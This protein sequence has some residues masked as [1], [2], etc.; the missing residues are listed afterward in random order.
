MNLQSIL[1]AGMTDHEAAAIEIM[2]GMTWRDHRCVALK[3]EL[4][5]GVPAQSALARACQSCVVDLF[6]LGMR[7]HSPDHEARLLEFLQGRSAVL[8]VWGSGGGWPDARLPLA[9]GQ[10]VQWLSMP[11]SSAALR[12]AI[13]VVK[14]AAE[15]AT[16]PVA[17]REPVPRRPE[18][19]VTVGNS[20]LPAEPAA[21]PAPATRPAPAPEEKVPAWRRAL[22]MADRLQA[23]RAPAPTPKTT[24]PPPAVRIRPVD[25]PAFSAPITGAAPLP[26]RAAV[27][28]TES[29]SLAP[30]MV[31]L[32][33]QALRLGQ[34]ALGALLAVF[35]SL[36]PLP[37][38]RL[39]DETTGGQSARLLAIGQSA[40]VMDF[41]GGWLAS[42]L[43]VSAL[44]KM[45][46]T[47]QLLESVRVLPLPPEQ[48]EE[49]VRQHFGGRFI[50]AQKP[51][52]VI[53]WELTS[54]AI[55]GDALQAHG[56]L[57]FQ[58]HRFPNFTLLDEVGPLD[59]QL[60]AI[61]A[62]MPQSISDLRRAFPQHERDVHRF[63]VLCVVSGL[64]VVLPAAP[65]T[66]AA[67]PAAPRRAE[68]VD[69]TVRRGFFKSLLEKLF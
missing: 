57:S 56:D 58:L 67:T 16:S 32:S 33:D 8:L 64:A 28:G 66:A 65:A 49:T 13:K 11:Y 21:A 5:L 20:E 14:T 30:P 26:L 12:D 68:G 62:R 42:G 9:P 53:T 46:H 51:L 34:G 10:N 48:V 24:T 50:K 7:K 23:T 2:V 36:R 40:F 63:V 15:R 31:R 60:A 55:A 19:V 22:Q 44:L 3:R 17:A 27:R 4:S 18:F 6:G 37:F 25:Q 41:R 69:T 38:I 29:V 43:P 1:L 54:D 52:D 59:V 39:V 35:P 47:P 61:C 45:M